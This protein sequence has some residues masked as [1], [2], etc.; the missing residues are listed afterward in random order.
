MDADSLIYMPREMAEVLR[1]AIRQSGISALQ[2]GGITGVAQQTISQ[3]L[4]GKDIRLK[5]AQK[6]A[7]HFGLELTSAEPKRRRR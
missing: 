2:L 3:F 1:A 5:T 6:L 7:D 4:A